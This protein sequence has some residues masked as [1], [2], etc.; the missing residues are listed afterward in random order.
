MT[1]RIMLGI[2]TFLPAL[3]KIESRFALVSLWVIPSSWTVNKTVRSIEGIAKI[4]VRRWATTIGG[5][6]LRYEIARSRRESVA[7]LAYHIVGACFLEGCLASVAG[8]EVLAVPTPE[9]VRGAEVVIL[10]RRVVQFTAPA[11]RGFT[12]GNVL[13]LNTVALGLGEGSSGAGAPGLDK[14]V[15][16]EV[17]DARVKSAAVSVV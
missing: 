11:V 8:D 13:W 7:E 4:V 12:A 1:Q 17:P 16:L 5:S 9:P 3:V 14:T 6:I 10:W 15:L 2:D